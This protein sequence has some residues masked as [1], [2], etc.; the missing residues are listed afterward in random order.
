[1]PEY[2]LKEL[3][4]K[5]GDNGRL[6]GAIPVPGGKG[7]STTGFSSHKILSDFELAF[8]LQEVRRTFSATLKNLRS[9]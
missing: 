2:N 7:T 5:N 9:H 1:M 4:N 6:E 8:S 3:I